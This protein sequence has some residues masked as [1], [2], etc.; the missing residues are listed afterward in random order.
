MTREIESAVKRHYGAK[1]LGDRILAGLKAMGADP[2]RPSVD[3]L[4]MVDEFH[5]AGRPATEYVLSRMRLS[6][7]LHLLDVG[8]GIGGAARL[9]AA[10][11][12]TRVTGIDL[13]P[14]FVE[15][16]RDLTRR[17]GLGDLVDLREA[18][19]LALP[20]EAKSFDA[21][22]TLH[23]A[24]NI[25]DRARLYGEVARVLK[26]GAEFAVYDLMKGPA[27]GPVFPV[28]WAETPATSFLKSPEETRALLEAA[29]FAVR[30]AEDRTAF[31]IEMMERQR[32]AAEGGSGP[33]P[34]SLSQLIG[35]AQ[36][37]L[38]NVADAMRSGAIA[39]VLIL[40]ERR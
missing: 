32:A 22:I 37:K 7:K 21:A 29:G 5:V 3:E 13:T 35:N 36:T 20:F 9:A 38:R 19:A 27:E 6:E 24:M 31:G 25:A 28:P 1:E 26:A 8:C 15:V 30:F 14:E 12:G 11:F 39:P 10:R 23:V 17:A 18:S 40:A 2:E 33:A 16:G 4:G 34:L